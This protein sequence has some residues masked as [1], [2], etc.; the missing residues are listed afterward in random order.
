MTDLRSVRKAATELEYSLP[1]LDSDIRSSQAELKGVDATNG[2]A[3]GSTDLLL[4]R[5]LSLTCLPGV[6]CPDTL[7]LGWEATRPLVANV[8]V[9]KTRSRS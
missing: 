1:W 5:V 9:M 3:T 8:P 7:F 6:T 2:V 4:L